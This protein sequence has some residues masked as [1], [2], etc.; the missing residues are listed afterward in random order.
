MTP[1][2]EAKNRYAISF[3]LDGTSPPTSKSPLHSSS[4][5]PVS[6]LER[7]LLGSTFEKGSDLRLSLET[8]SQAVGGNI[9]YIV[10]KGSYHLASY[11]L[12]SPRNTDV[13]LEEAAYEVYRTLDDFDNLINPDPANT[14][15]LLRREKDWLDT[16]LEVLYRDSDLESTAD[17]IVGIVR[18]RPLS[19]TLE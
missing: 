11:H 2:E 6:S 17:V 8:R 10:Y 16:F 18:Q 15:L 19:Y 9:R 4:S 12:A 3:L 14:T 5:C 7:D 1:I 13:L